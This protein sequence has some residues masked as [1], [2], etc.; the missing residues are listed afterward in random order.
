MGNINSTSPE[1]Q[2]RIRNFA[3]RIDPAIDVPTHFAIAS[4]SDTDGANDNVIR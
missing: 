4:V 2:T 1:I 3:I